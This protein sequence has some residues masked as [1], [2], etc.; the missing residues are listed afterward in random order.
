[1]D[2][3]FT[4]QGAIG[5][6]STPI[7]GAMIGLGF[8]ILVGV[9][10][11]MGL[12][13]I[14][15]WWKNKKSYNVPVTIFIPRSNN[16]IIEDISAVGGYFRTKSRD[17][18]FVT[19]FRLKR[20]GNPTIDLPPPSSHFLV[21]LNKKLYLIQKGVDDF[22]PVDPTGFRYITTQKGRK[23]PIIDLKCINQDA[24]AWV[25]DN[26]ENAKRRFTF[27]GLWEKYKD[28]IQI[29]VFVFIVFLA[30]YINW[31]GLKEVAQAL[32]DVA[33]QL[34]GQPLIS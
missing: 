7:I 14:F 34:K 9:L 21:G 24:T 29:T 15:V 20:K 25:E 22:E 12:I 27:H 30:I 18:G 31:Q 19:T 26:R 32:Q 10:I 11:L 6:V 1:M 2:N 17:G 13:L 4:E 28:M 23:I 5:G 33:T 3:P 16:K 8:K